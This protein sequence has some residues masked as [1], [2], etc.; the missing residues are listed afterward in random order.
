MSEMARQPGLFR[1]RAYNW[2]RII[3]NC[4]N[5]DLVPCTENEILSSI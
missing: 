1:K 2:H 3:T 5:V 4:T